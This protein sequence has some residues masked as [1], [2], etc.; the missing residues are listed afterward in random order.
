MTK[1]MSV[2]SIWVMTG[3]DKEKVGITGGKE[4]RMD[5]GTFVSWIEWEVVV[6]G[7]VGMNHI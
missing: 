6:E 2:P 3:W 4:G 1:G 7:K 5:P